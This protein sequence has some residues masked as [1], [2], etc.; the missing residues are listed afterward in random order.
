MTRHFSI[1][2]ASLV[3]LAGLAQA[4]TTLYVDQNADQAPHDGSDWCHAYLTLD[5][6]LAYAGNNSSVSEIRVADGIYVPDPA[7]L[8][9]P[10]EATFALI[11]GVAARGGYDPFALL[12][13][14]TTIDS[15]SPDSVE[16]TVMMNTH[17]PTG[18][19]LIRLA[20]SMD[21]KLDY[22]AGGQSNSKRF[23]Q[24]SAVP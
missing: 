22:Y 12:D 6:A 11:N 18:E 15:I 5:E 24:V 2:L 16:L 23:Q 8:G 7:G 14:L 19:R 20:D 17:P 3:A 1:G 21:G 10:R 4:Q 9:N 13:V